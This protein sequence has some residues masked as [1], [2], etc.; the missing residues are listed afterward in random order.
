MPQLITYKCDCEGCGQVA[1]QEQPGQEISGW[2]GIGGRSRNGQPVIIC[3][4]D[5]DA[6][7]YLLDSGLLVK[8]RD[9]ETVDRVAKF[10]DDQ[11][12]QNG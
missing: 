2:G 7:V 12:G 1:T 9:R 10:L 5:T 11:G 3:P 4:A 6:I 8:L